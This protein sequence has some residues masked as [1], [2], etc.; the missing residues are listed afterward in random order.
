M[1]RR[2]GDFW[3]AKYWFRKVGPHPVLEQLAKYL[4]SNQK[5][6]PLV[7]SSSLPIRDLSNPAKI[8][9]ALVDSCQWALSSQPEQVSILQRICWL[10]WQFLFQYGWD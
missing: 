7:Q 9:S 5:A 8:A 2:E 10:E 3:N 6:E 1:H 4:S